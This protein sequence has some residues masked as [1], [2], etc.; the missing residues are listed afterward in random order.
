MPDSIMYQ[1]DAYVVLETNQLEQFLTPEELLA[2][3]KGILVSRQD[4]LPRDLQKFSSVDEQAKYLMETSCE[5]D[6]EPGEYLQW[7]VVRLAK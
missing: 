1:E 7:Y 2:K 3:L 5:L 6:V 4:N